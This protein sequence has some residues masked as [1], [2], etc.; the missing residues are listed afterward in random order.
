MDT[1]KQRQRRRDDAKLTESGNARS[2]QLLMVPTELL[3]NR[4]W[5]EWIRTLKAQLIFRH[6]ISDLNSPCQLHIHDVTHK[7]V[8]KNKKRISIYQQYHCAAVP[9]GVR[10]LLEMKNSGVIKQGQQGKASQVYTYSVVG[11]N[12]CLL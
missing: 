10:L 7:C 8:V 1:E 12:G 4:V 2:E 9:P 11:L 5:L 3:T 6:E